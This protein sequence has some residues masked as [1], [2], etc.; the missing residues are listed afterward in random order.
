MVEPRLVRRLEGCSTT[1]PTR[2]RGH[3]DIP[4]LD[5]GRLDIYAVPTAH[6]KKGTLLCVQ[7]VRS[8]GRPD[9]EF[10]QQIDASQPAL[11]RKSPPSTPDAAGREPL[12]EEVIIRRRHSPLGEK[13]YR[14]NYF[15]VQQNDELP[16]N[17]PALQ[18][19]PGRQNRDVSI[20]SDNFA[21]GVCLSVEGENGALL[22]Q[23]LRPRMPG[24][25]AHRH[26]ASE[27]NAKELARRLKSMSLADT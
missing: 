8:D 7:A 21:R 27:L 20:R 4:I 5:G 14:N 2:I 15:L 23:L 13:R 16:E 11:A 25:N 3:T 17:G 22:R 9:R 19:R 18:G 24:G 26:V 6:P 12:S 1:S 10:E